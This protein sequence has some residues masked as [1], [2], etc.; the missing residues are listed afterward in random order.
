MNTSA[1]MD[2]MLLLRCYLC[3]RHAHRL[4]FRYQ[5][6]KNG[7]FL[8]P[9]SQLSTHPASLSSP[10]RTQSGAHFISWVS[11]QYVLRLPTPSPSLWLKA[12][13]AFLVGQTSVKG[14]SSLSSPPAHLSSTVYRSARAWP[15]SP[16]RLRCHLLFEAI[17][18]PCG[19]V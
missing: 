8:S 13:M 18:S 7:L 11:T 12:H 17:S 19:P 3:P 14:I 4:P 5:P 9:R 15:L 6:R 2:W 10:E 1:S 16:L